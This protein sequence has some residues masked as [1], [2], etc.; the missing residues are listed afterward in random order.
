MF[1][2]PFEH[3]LSPII[4]DEIEAANDRKSTPEYHIS[5]VGQNVLLE[6]GWEWPDDVSEETKKRFG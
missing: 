4:F 1:K 2:V 5:P 3:I 6:G